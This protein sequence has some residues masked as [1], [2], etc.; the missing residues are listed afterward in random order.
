MRAIYVK[1]DWFRFRLIPI[2][3]RILLI[4]IAG[5]I[6]IALSSRGIHAVINSMFFDGDSFQLSRLI[7]DLISITLI[8]LFWN[9]LYFGYSFFK[10]FYFQEINNLSIEANL[11]EMEFKNLRN[12]LNPHFLF[13]S[14]NSIKALILIDPAKAKESLTILSN[15]LRSSLAFS[16]EGLIP[17]AKE[18]ELVRNYLKLEKMRFE[19]RLM[20]EWSIQDDIEH[21]NV[22]PLVLQMMVENAVKHGISNLV[23]GGKIN[24]VISQNERGLVIQVKNTGQMQENEETF[25]IGLENTKRRL[26]LQYQSRASMLMYEEEDMVVSQIMLKDEG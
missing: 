23:Q 24:I 22:P 9:T 3:P 1:Q 26:D 19:E 11:R 5:G 16:S 10:K 2:L 12:Q 14:L 15:L 25:G 7:V 6:F 8:V 17:L 13:N 18:V 4:S 21:I 20:V